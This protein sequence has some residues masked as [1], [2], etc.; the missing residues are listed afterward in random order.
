[1]AT[2]VAKISLFDAAKDERSRVAP[3]KPEKI[4]PVNVLI[5]RG[6][7]GPRGSIPFYV[8]STKDVA[9]FVGELEEVYS[10]KLDFQNIKIPYPIDDGVYS[11]FRNQVN[12][13]ISLKQWEEREH[14][15]LTFG[16]FAESPASQSPL[17]LKLKVTAYIYKVETEVYANPSSS[18][19][20]AM[21]F[22]EIE[23]PH[24]SFTWRDL[25]RN[26]ERQFPS[27]ICAQEGIEANQALVTFEWTLLGE[28]NDNVVDSVIKTIERGEPSSSTKVRANVLG[29]LNAKISVCG[30]GQG[31]FEFASTQFPANWDETVAAFT[32]KIVAKLKLQVGSEDAVCLHLNGNRRLLDSKTFASLMINPAKDYLTVDVIRGVAGKLTVHFDAP[33]VCPRPNLGVDVTVTRSGSIEVAYDQ[34]DTGASL[35]AKILDFVPDAEQ[36]PAVSR[37]F[38]I[39][40]T[41]KIIFCNDED[42]LESLG[43]FVGDAIGYYCFYSYQIAVKTLTGKNITILVGSDDS[44]DDLM[45]KIQDKEGI[46]PEQQRLIFGGLQFQEGRALSDY[47]I[48]EDSTV[49]LVLR[50]R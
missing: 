24:S 31:D 35:L 8:K 27:L 30:V 2:A 45:A 34:S 17:P 29:Y 6:L 18:T 44:V 26:F 20:T 43:V 33:L 48:K 5:D 41:K 32:K 4:I 40:G 23:I 16:K 21:S 13:L 22:V 39:R 37:R 47:N 10:V 7:E 3:K 50:L 1:M 42:T 49:H 15:G 36:I 38:Y 25:K 46:P 28:D 12:E 11:P 14:S 9:E 19:K